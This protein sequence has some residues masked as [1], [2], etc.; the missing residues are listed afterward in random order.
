MKMFGKNEDRVIDNLLRANTRG[1]G[2]AP[3]SCREF[4]PDLAN[5]YI[6]RSLTASERAGYE[7]HM[8]ECH[9]CRSSVVRLARMAAPASF[10]Q[11]VSEPGRFA[12]LKGL[13]TAPLLP[14]VAA[15]AL[16][17]I[18]LA[19]S[20]PLLVSRKDS[21]TPPATTSSEI[22]RDQMKDRVGNLPVAPQAPPAGN[23]ISNAPQVT[24]PTSEALSPAKSEKEKAQPAQDEAELAKQ[25]PAE[26]DAAA[27]GARAARL[28]PPQTEKLDAS[29][30]AA[31]NYQERKTEGDAQ[32]IAKDQPPATVAPPPPAPEQ[33]PLGQIKAEDALRL[34]Q[35][36]KEA[37]SVTIRPGLPGG[38]PGAERGRT[39]RSGDA[40][41]PSRSEAGGSGTPR[42]GLAASPRAARERADAS[43]SDSARG[44]NMRKVGSKKFWLSK[45][46]WTDKDYNPNKEMPV[47]TVERD[48]DIFK[49][50]LTKR[51]GLKLYLMGF[52]EGERAIFVYKGTVYRLIPQNSR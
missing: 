26:P 20:I 17:L 40:V 38:V 49:E 4:D 9:A 2:G 27:T 37:P 48:S 30:A 10:A 39:I 11:P 21:A 36:D 19:I 43:D 25:A 45:D 1:R 12:T 32:L 6:E 34:Q 5:A 7:L 14:R 29:R 47:V 13:F 15:A 35:R 16:A 51:S 23:E 42:G 31:S 33:T 22:A 18:V 50:L 52:A 46:T 28:E 3:T 41:A 8:S 44:S 24:T